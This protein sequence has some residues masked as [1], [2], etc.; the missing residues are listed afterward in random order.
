MA[1]SFVGTYE[2]TL[3]V[4][5]RVSLPSKFRKEFETDSL[6]LA[7]GPNHE[8]SVFTM[9]SFNEWLDSLFDEEGGFNSKNAT[10]VKRRRFFANQAAFADVDKAGRIN[11]PQ[12]HIDWAGLDKTVLVSGD[13]DHVS[14]WDKDRYNE[15]MNAYDPM[16][17]YASMLSE[18]AE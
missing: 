9:D 12:N 6:V 15:Y 11:I 7:P 2:H 17:L 10:H 8:I 4:K 3:D 5:G 14:L 18:S 13:V 16:E 1:G